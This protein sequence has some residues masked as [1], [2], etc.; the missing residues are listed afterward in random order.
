MEVLIEH[1]VTI[2][3]ID[4]RAAMKN[5]DIFE[6]L[7]KAGANVNAS[8]TGIAFRILH[9]AITSKDAEILKILIKHGAK[10]MPCDLLAAISY[11]NIE[12]LKVLL[13]QLGGINELYNRT[14]LLHLAIEFRNSM[15]V[16]G[17]IDLGADINIID[18]K[19]GTCIEHAK[20][21]GSKT[22]LEILKNAGA[23][24]YCWH[25]FYILVKRQSI[26]V[27]I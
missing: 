4:L 24:L 22:C 7:L 18:G 25:L 20:E 26:P 14:T 27:T 8:S 13:E 23:I 15:M 2:N 19:H 10:I 9:S 1:N 21:T 3:F 12:C 11:S 17:I 16:Q 5:K 6:A